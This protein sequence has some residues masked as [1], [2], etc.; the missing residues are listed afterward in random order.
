M[1]L[2][3]A[4]LPIAL[5]FM[6]L[7]AGCSS[8]DTITVG[9]QTFTETKIL[10]YMYKYLIE[11]NSNVN[12][13]VKTDLSS[14]PFIVNAL[15][16]NEIQLGT[17]YTGEIFN[18][19]FPIQQTKDKQ[20]VLAQ[21]QRGFSK[22]YHFKWYNPLGFE[23]TYAFTVT[24][25]V[26]DK[27][28]LKKISD[29]KKVSK[30]MRLGVDTSWMERD[31]DGYKP[32]VKTYGLSFKNV[33]PMEI[34]LVYKAVASKQMDIVLA[35]S[36]DARI[37]QYHLVTLEDDRHFFPPYDAS[38]VVLED[39]LKKYPNID[40]ALQK[41]SGKININTIRTL[42][43]KVDIDMQEPEQVAKEFLQQQGL[44]KK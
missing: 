41:L 14:S 35:Y 39:T 43:A 19:W 27:Y 23:N 26:A 9:T 31:N 6:I 42:N 20:K 30:N 3:K 12:V 40:K 32:F 21:A 4:L 17:L 38:T 18:N 37:K 1:K 11:Q 22:Y 36:S 25:E 15:R 29:L 8:K 10:G 28:H 13:D 16:E 2:Q 5:S 24:K 44:L 34:N 7:L 33:F